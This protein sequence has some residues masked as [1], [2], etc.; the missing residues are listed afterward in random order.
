VQYLCP[1]LYILRA[2]PW[3]LELY[4]YSTPHTTVNPVLLPVKYMSL[5]CGMTFWKITTSTIGFMV[6]SLAGYAGYGDRPAE[7]LRLEI[8]KLIPGFPHKRTDSG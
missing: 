1:Q 7:T 5:C 2:V 3:D 6:E 4:Y 8:L